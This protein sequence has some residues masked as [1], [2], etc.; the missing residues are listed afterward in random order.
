[1][2][3]IV[4]RGDIW[5]LVLPVILVAALGVMALGSPAP[6]RNGTEAGTDPD[7]ER[8]DTPLPE[9]NAT[10]DIPPGPAEIVRLF[11]LDLTASQVTDLES[12]DLLVVDLKQRY[13][14]GRADY[15]DMADFANPELLLALYGLGDGPR[16]EFTNLVTSEESSQGGQAV[17]RV[18]YGLRVSLPDGRSL[19]G[20][21][22]DRLVPLELEDG[23]W[24]IV[25][26]R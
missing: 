21:K 10:V 16:I 26:L 1:M 6:A 24:K 5:G 2:R 3:R 19:S 4:L 22:E 13:F 11:F 12:A 23:Q 17:V 9:A 15:A 20:D 25:H 18:A 14:V 8:F 7:A